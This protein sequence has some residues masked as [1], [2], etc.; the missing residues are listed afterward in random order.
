VPDEFVLK[1]SA[2]GTPEETRAKVA[3]YK[4]RGCTCPILYPMSDPFLMI[5]TFVT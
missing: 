4:R 1:I 5:D 3:E 2:T